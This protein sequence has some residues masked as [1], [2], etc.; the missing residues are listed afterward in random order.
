MRRGSNR[1]ARGRFTSGPD[2]KFTPEQRLAYYSDAV[3]AV[4]RGIGPLW[5]PDVLDCIRDG[6]NPTEAAAE[7]GLSKS[8]VYDY[9][10]DPTG[11]RVRERKRKY[12]HPCPQ[13]GAIVNPN[14]KRPTTLCVDCIREDAEAKARPI[15]KLWNEGMPEWAVAEELGISRNKVRGAIQ[16]ARGWG[17]DVQLHRARNRT[18]WPT[19]RRLVRAGKTASEIG[20]AIGENAHNVR[21]QVRAMR[22]AG[23]KVEW[24]HPRAGC[25]KRTA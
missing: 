5:L 18:N 22:R 9:L 11:E 13:C 15:V 19:I 21:V 10:V 24:K 2:V 20:E 23:Y 7:L 6:M 8:S 3:E 12:A 4:E 1:D 16:Q 17:W 14:G 25:G